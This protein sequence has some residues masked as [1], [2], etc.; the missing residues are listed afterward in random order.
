[1]DEPL[2]VFL[3]SRVI[4]GCMERKKGLSSNPCGHFL[5]NHFADLSE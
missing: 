3:Q 1:M 5:P 2:K 4:P